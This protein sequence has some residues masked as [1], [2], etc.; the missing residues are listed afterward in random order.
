[1]PHALVR[2]KP[3]QPRWHRRK[4]ARPAEIVAAALEVFVERGFSA[5]RL[6]DVA[7]RA[8]VTK[9][10]VYLYFA[11]KE[12]LFKA[13]V[14]ETIVPAIA[15][16]EQMVSAHRGSAADLFRQLLVGWWRLIGETNLSG[17][18]KLVMAEAGNF[19]ELARFYYDEVIQRGHRLVGTVLERG[20][21]SGEFRPVDVRLAVRLAFAPL[22]HAANWRHSFA[23]CT[24]E[25]FDVG[26]YLES[27]MDI[28]LRGI[29][30]SPDGTE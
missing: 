8:G 18:P 10:T 29:A 27:H 30:N 14:R 11:S 17:I 15:A 24:G 3:L 5:A 7:R 16:G 28:F 12:A 2:S 13:M 6:T 20:I 21:A 4:E 22:L 9:G 23:L 19:P 26:R 25:G 1:M